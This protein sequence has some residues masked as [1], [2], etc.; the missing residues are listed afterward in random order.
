MEDVMDFSE[1]L[2]SNSRDNKMLAE[3]YLKARKKYNHC[4]N[5]LIVLVQKAGLNKSKKSIDNKIIELLANE[6]YTDQ[7]NEYYSQMLSAEAEY[8]GLQ[9]VCK[10]YA[11]HSV[12]LC[13]IIKMQQQGEISEAVRSKY[14]KGNDYE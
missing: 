3:E 4:F 10:A 11:N 6:Q 2:L 12:A 9:E 8:K 14:M 5:Q 1:E 13:S 7:A